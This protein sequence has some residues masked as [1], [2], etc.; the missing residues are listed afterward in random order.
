M[1]ALGHFFDYL[2]RH[3]IRRIEILWIRPLGLDF[4]S[5]HIQLFSK[6][7]LALANIGRESVAGNIR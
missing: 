5:V 7:T 6:S 2:S 1:V 4:H 3:R